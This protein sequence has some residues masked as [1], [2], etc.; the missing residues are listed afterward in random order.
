MERDNSYG[1]NN[2][3]DITS[4]VARE[5]DGLLPAAALR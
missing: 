5:M 1:W 4:A 2:E 3:M